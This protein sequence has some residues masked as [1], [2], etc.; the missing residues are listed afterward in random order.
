MAFRTYM[1]LVGLPD[2][3]FWGD[4]AAQ[5]DPDHDILPVEKV[6]RICQKLQTNQKLHTVEDEAT[7]DQLGETENEQHIIQVL[8]AATQL[9]GRELDQG[10]PAASIAD[11]AVEMT[12]RC[13]CSST[14]V[15]ECYRVRGTAYGIAAQQCKCM[16]I[17]CKQNV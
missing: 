3:I 14:L 13:E 6:N 10:K 1:E 8:L 16:V 9:F 7:A 2:V 11:I 17:K 5:A 4:A 12:R 15:A